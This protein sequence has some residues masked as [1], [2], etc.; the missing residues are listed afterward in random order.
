MPQMSA[1][2][3]Y[4][5]PKKEKPWPCPSASR[6]PK[7][8]NAVFKIFVSLWGLKPGTTVSP[9]HSVLW[10]S[11]LCGVNQM[12]AKTHDYGVNLRSHGQAQFLVGSLVSRLLLRA[13]V[14]FPSR[15]HM[16]LGYQNGADILI[17]GNFLNS[18]WWR[19][20]QTI[21]SRNPLTLGVV[22]LLWY[23]E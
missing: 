10:S 22:L 3:F 20:L 23:E 14:V 13:D 5:R 17:W 21:F 9:L 4:P 2:F 16:T 15:D 1:P 12:F 6:G 18:Y 19:P 7:I 11:S 8:W